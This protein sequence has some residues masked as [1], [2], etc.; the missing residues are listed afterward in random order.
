MVKKIIPNL[1]LK[2]FAN[3]GFDKSKAN[4]RINTKINKHIKHFMQLTRHEPHHEKNILEQRKHWGR[5]DL[6]I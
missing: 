1:R 5:L 4:I 3:L 2:K 6:I